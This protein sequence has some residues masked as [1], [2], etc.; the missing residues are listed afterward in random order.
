[1]AELKIKNL[2]KNTYFIPSPTNIGIYVQDK[3]TVLIDSGNDKEAGRYILRTLR[4]K[5]W[6]LKLIINTHSN[7][8]HAGGNAYLQRKTGC[9]IASPGIE[10]A[11]IEYPELEP[12]FL[13]GGYPLKKHKNKFLMARPSKVT[14]I[15]KNTGKILD[16]NLF[17]ES[18]KGHFFDMI[19]IKTPDN[20]FFIGD[21][22][23]PKRIIKK[24][25]LFY[26][27]DV[28]SYLKTLDILE[29]DTSE[30]FVPSH[31]KPTDD[32]KS[33]VELN[34]QK[35]DEICDQIEKITDEPKTAEEI[36]TEILRNYRISL[37]ENQY[38]LCFNTIKSYLSYLSGKKRIKYYFKDH[39]MLWKKAS[40]T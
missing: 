40:Q 24:Y 1:M 20:V 38:I 16:T 10:K 34:K 18:L 6:N 33:I 19:G 12:A 32:L 9:S 27:F 4:K 39:Q 17:A 15:I 5:D 36:L 30:I 8:D 37:N 7:A 2:R 26:I 29:K 3:N 21:S 22:I 14:D 28:L 11:F 25:H 13:Y 23:F 31:G 35:I